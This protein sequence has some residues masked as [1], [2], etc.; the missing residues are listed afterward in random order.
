MNDEA[1]GIEL[2]GG[3][4]QINGWKNVYSGHELGGWPPPERLA[5]LMVMSRVA[6]ALVE[7]V[8]DEFKGDVH[9]YRKVH[10][11]SLP[12]AGS[13]FFRGAIYEYVK[14]HD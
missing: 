5:A 2:V 8:P 11:S 7:N 1:I 6:V 9:Y 4:P 3:P 10:Q 14:D 13:G 12:A